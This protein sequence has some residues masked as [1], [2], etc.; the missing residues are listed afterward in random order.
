MHLSLNSLLRKTCSSQCSLKWSQAFLVS[1]TWAHD[2][3]L[4]AAKVKKL[5]L[6]LLAFEALP[7][8]GRLTT[9]CSLQTH[10]QWT[11]EAETEYTYMT[12][13]TSSFD[14]NFTSNEPSISHSR[15]DWLQVSYFLFQNFIFAIFNCSLASIYHSARHNVCTIDST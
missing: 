6:L 7:R 9:V 12:S 5:T 3:T 4:A 10:A 13:F 2:L 8:T 14:V 1:K 11:G 15:L